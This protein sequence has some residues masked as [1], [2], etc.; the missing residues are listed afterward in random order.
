MKQRL[1]K[2][3]RKS[4]AVQMPP[5]QIIAGASN[6][7]FAKITQGILQIQDATLVEKGGS[8]GLKVYE[9]LKKDGHASSVL[10]KRKMAVVAYEWEVDP[11]TDDA[12]DVK[13]ADG[14]REILKTLKI[15]KLTM[16][17]LEATLMGFAVA[18][19]EWCPETW[20]PI[21]FHKRD[22]RRFL[23]DVE[24]HLRLITPEDRQKGIILPDRKFIVHSFGS[25][26]DDPYGLG[27]GS[28]LFWLVFFKQRDIR[29]WARFAE[30]FGSPTVLGKYPDHMQKDQ[31]QVF[32]DALNSASQETAIIAPLGSEVELMQAAASGS[33][34]TYEKL[35]RYMDEEMSKAVLGETLTTSVGETGSY[36]AAKTH[37]GV[38][39]ELVKADADL[40]SDTLNESLLTW[41]TEF[42]FP[43][44]NPPRFWRK[45]EAPVDK[46]TEADKDTKVAGLGFEPEEEMIQEKYGAGWK[47]KTMMPGTDWDGPGAMD[48]GQL[49][50]DNE[51]GGL[52]RDAANQGGD[53]PG[54]PVQDTAL[55]GAQVSSLL[56]VCENVAIGKLPKASATAIIMAAFPAMAPDM[57]RGMVEPIEAKEPEPAQ[58][59][60]EVIE[61]EAEYAEK[62][63]RK[64][65]ASDILTDR[66]EQA[67]GDALDGLLEPVRR[68]VS[69]AKSYS[70]VIDGIREI[71]PDMDAENFAEIMK[72]A[73]VASNLAGASTVR[74]GRNG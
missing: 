27:L 42:H 4:E 56:Q 60:Q 15:A 37:N 47:K 12:A 51:G 6:D 16:G 73:F 9:K 19:I 13:A 61:V 74:H 66:L 7:P 58:P 49:T 54:G 63:P 44:A 3:Q 71:Y 26:T 32:L 48:N 38:R 28:L 33:I 1:A 69:E 5:P 10:Q 21:K 24:G 14:I 11:A 59:K 34:D 62:A 67:A 65:D 50:I 35:A 36:A 53:V 64:K 31:Q 39:L 43:G 30:K 57:V 46:N 68:L 22:Q 8:D 2:K 41:L 70:E 25:E 45:V 29:F 23:F 40:L 55:N 17:L 18:E 52:R 20:L 72:E